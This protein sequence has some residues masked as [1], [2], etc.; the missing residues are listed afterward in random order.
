MAT[1]SFRSTFVMIALCAGAFMTGCKSVPVE[2]TALDA[3]ETLKTGT[4]E[5]LVD[6]PEVRKRYLGEKFKLDR[7][8]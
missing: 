1:T 7:Y 5:E 8:E 3:P 4:A 2:I 6:D